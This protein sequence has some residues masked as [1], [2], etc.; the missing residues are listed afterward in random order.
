MLK[1]SGKKDF[2]LRKNVLF[3]NIGFETFQISP[4]F[5]KMGF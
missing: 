4:C 1:N 2:F 3:K 5:Q